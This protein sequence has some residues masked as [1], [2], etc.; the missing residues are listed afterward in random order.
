MKRRSPLPWLVA[1]LAIAPLL[2]LAVDAHARP[3]G[4]SSYSG[5]SRGGGGGFG[6]GGGS[7]GGGGGGGGG[8]DA[9]GAVVWFIF[10]DL[11]WPLKLIVVGAIVVVFVVSKVRRSGM[12]DWSSS[13]PATY[14]PQPRWNPPVHALS[15]R[16]RLEGLRNFDPDF[17]V[18]LFEDFLYALYSTTKYSA[19]GRM[20]R[21]SAYLAPDVLARLASS[22]A[23]EVHTVIVGAVRFTDVR[24]MQSV[25]GQAE[26]DVEI[27]SNVPLPTTRLQCEQV[28]ATTASSGAPQ[29]GQARMVAR[30]GGR[31]WASLRR[32]SVQRSSR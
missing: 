29:P 25:Q 27:E 12:Q 18:I 19:A 23:A 13:A 3:G 32:V 26:V 10:S 5:G 9:L 28:P 16:R 11:P 1:F 20:D 22:P 6:G 15:T 7:Y 31:E 21:L 30:P 24:G 17:S 14:T 2:L 4:G 8:G